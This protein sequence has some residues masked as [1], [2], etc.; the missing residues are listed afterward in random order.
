MLEISLENSLFKPFSCMGKK[1][2]LNISLKNRSSSDFV[3][4]F[5]CLLSN[6]FPADFQKKIPILSGWKIQLSN[7]ATDPAGFSLLCNLHNKRTGR[8]RIS[9]EGPNAL[10]ALSP[11]VTI[12]F[13]NIIQ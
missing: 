10:E 12:L 2:K 13:G 3:F 7:F 5:V 4:V 1:W 11:K 8:L 9:R 6:K